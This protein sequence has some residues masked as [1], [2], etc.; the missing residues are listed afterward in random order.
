MLH[1]WMTKEGTAL[2][3]DGSKLEVPSLEGHGGTGGQGWCSAVLWV[4]LCARVSTLQVP[5]SPME[6]LF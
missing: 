4:V 3:S 2:Y 1:Q 5:K 6:C